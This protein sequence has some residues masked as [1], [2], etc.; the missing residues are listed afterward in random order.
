MGTKRGVVSGGQ[1]QL[2]KKTAWRDA[3]ANGEKKPDLQERFL[4]WKTL[5]RTSSRV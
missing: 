5:R 3:K 1:V 2:E 4:S